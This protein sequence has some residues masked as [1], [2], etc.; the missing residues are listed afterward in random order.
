MTVAG[1]LALGPDA[2]GV[3]TVVATAVLCY[4]AAAA[5]K[6]RWVAWAGCLVFPTV[7]VASRLAGV[8][9]WAVVAA[10]A[11]ALVVVGL[12]IRA[13]RPPLSAQTLALVGYG[14]VAVVALFLAPRA[15]LALAGV[16]LAD[17]DFHLELFGGGGIDPGTYY[18][19][20]IDSLERP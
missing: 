2:D 11:A 10:V 7:I 17:D 9:W 5:L 3:A 4:L 15:G 18:T 14:G 12:A 8:T 19:N 16:A 20:V 13:P 1:Q 6:R